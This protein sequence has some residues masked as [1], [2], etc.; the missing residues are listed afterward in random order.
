MLTAV[1]LRASSVKT[2]K[3]MSLEISRERL[4]Y[5]KDVALKDRDFGTSRY[6]VEFMVSLVEDIF[7]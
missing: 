1:A 2:Y 6:A 4:G 7:K 5:G 3:D